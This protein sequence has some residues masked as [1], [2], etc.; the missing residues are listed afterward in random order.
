MPSLQPSGLALPSGILGFLLMW[1]PG[2]GGGG[3]PRIVSLSFHH[4]CLKTG[5]P[6]QL[7]GG[8]RFL[9]SGSIGEAKV[10]SKP[11]L[12]PLALAT[13]KMPCRAGGPQVQGH[14]WSHRSLKPAW[15]TETLSETKDCHGLQLPRSPV[16]VSCRVDAGKTGWCKRV[17]ASQPLVPGTPPSV[18]HEGGKVPWLPR[19]PK[20]H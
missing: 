20:Q 1:D 19:T 16:L 12:D 4:L 8:S 17:G 13:L 10:P 6:W 7:W 2:P 9:P 14:P 3:V 15:D 11:A 5:S 18:S